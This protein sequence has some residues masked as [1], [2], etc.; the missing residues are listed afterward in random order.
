MVG[1][2]RHKQQQR[3]SSSCWE[4]QEIFKKNGLFESALQV[5]SES[6][7]ERLSDGL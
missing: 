6:V 2:T 5:E 4:E 1:N 7:E 3:K